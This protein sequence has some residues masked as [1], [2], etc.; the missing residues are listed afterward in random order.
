MGFVAMPNNEPVLDYSPIHSLMMST[1]KNKTSAKSAYVAKNIST[2]PIS[3]IS[4]IALQQHV[5][6]ES[7]IPIPG[8][9]FN[10]NNMNI[11]QTNPPML[12]IP[13]TDHDSNNSTELKTCD[14]SDDIH[15]E[16]GIP[17]NLDTYDANEEDMVT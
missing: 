11:T 13:Q 5:P 2:L 1:T 3:Q 7:N 9:N 12:T 17:D 16:N 6:P 4:T 10:P 8:Q 15:D 14:T